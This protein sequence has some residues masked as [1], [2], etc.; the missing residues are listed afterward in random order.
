MY[1]FIYVYRYTCVVGMLNIHIYLGP[2]FARL[3][4]QVFILPLLLLSFAFHT[5]TKLFAEIFLCVYRY[6]PTLLD[7]SL[8]LFLNALLPVLPSARYLFVYFIVDGV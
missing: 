1:I 8:Q 2:A 5:H 7:S 3:V 4:L 6:A